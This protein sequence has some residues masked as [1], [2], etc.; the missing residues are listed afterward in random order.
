MKKSILF[1][2]LVFVLCFSVFGETQGNYS[3]TPKEGVQFEDLDLYGNIYTYYSGRG[4]KLPNYIPAYLS[5]E[6]YLR[7]ISGNKKIVG[8]YVPRYFDGETYTNFRTEGFNPRNLTDI[9][10]SYLDEMSFTVTPDKTTNNKCNYIGYWQNSKS[11]VQNKLFEENKTLLSV[12]YYYDLG[13]SYIPEIKTAFYSDCS[14][15]YKYLYDGSDYIYL[16]AYGFKKDPII[17][18]WCDGV[19]D[20]YANPLRKV[21]AETLKIHY[22]ATSYIDIATK[23]FNDVTTTKNY[24]GTCTLAG[25]LIHDCI[26][27]T[28]LSNDIKER[29]DWMLDVMAGN[30]LP[31]LISYDGTIYGAGE[32]RNYFASID[33]YFNYCQEN[34][35]ANSINSWWSFKASREK[36]D[37][38][39]YMNDIVREQIGINED[40][41][42]NGVE[43]VIW[44]HYKN[45]YNIPTGTNLYPFNVKYTSIRCSEDQ[46]WTQMPINPLNP[47]AQTPYVECNFSSTD[48][49][50]V[51]ISFSFQIWLN[52]AFALVAGADSIQ[53]SYNTEY[54]QQMLSALQYDPKEITIKNYGGKI[55]IISSFSVNRSK[56]DGCTF[57]FMTPNQ[58]NKTIDAVDQALSQTQD[59]AE[60]LPDEVIKALD[61]QIKL[62]RSEEKKSQFFFYIDIVAKLIFR[63]FVLL[64]YILSMACIFMILRLIFVIP[65]QIIKVMNNMGKSKQKRQQDSILNKGM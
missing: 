24:D 23:M 42:Q 48:A 51:N 13:Y 15:I 34:Y 40:W 31:E 39:N 53:E 43:S 19:D 1:I 35:I 30:Y 3:S 46:E 56:E 44:D 2:V 20:T 59:N 38:D 21:M 65:T 52:P 6:M 29:D 33:P 4:L 22:N 45:T 36:L 12:Y 57:V 49:E 54:L 50:V 64:Y 41:T 26:S 58:V 55:D 28:Q 10:K 47:N 63:G 8:R 37:C 9:E 14:E 32:I 18:K 5:Q 61:A 62:L 11:F 60:R 17:N 25:T 27:E 16:T 7:N